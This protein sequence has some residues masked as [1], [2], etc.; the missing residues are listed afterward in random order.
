MTKNLLLYLL[1]IAF[2]FN[3]FNSFYYIMFA[4][5][6]LVLFRRKGRIYIDGSIVLLGIWSLLFAIMEIIQTGSVT[7]LRNLVYVFAFF[8]GLNMFDRPK[9]KD[10]IAVVLLLGASLSGYGLLNFIA[11]YSNLQT[12]SIARATFDFWSGEVVTATSQ[13]AYFAFFLS[14]ILTVFTTIRGK[15]L[16]LLWGLILALSFVY[17]LMLAGRTYF[18]LLAVGIVVGMFYT[19][20]MNDVVTD[21]HVVSRTKKRI[22]W[23]L[24]LV[25]LV[26]FALFSFDA[27]GVYTKLMSSNFYTRFFTNTSITSINESGRSTLMA[28]FVKLMMDYPWG[29][30]N[31]SRLMGNNVHNMWLDNYD[32]LGIIPF[33]LLVSYSCTAIFRVMQLIRDKE[34]STKL[35]VLGISV[36]M[37]LFAQYMLEPILSG[38]QWLFVAFCL[39]DGLMCAQLKRGGTKLNGY[40]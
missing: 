40:T 29:G 3:I 37:V 24:L 12:Y 23:D 7:K 36:Y 17:N 2:G 15:L 11:N 18:G 5:A 10:T 16:K 21:K 22:W 32:Q 33:V 13:A 27:F 31:I 26:V 38:I 34:I 14:T 35:R 30:S 20:T 1:I 9:E 4:I 19:T 28:E 8:A 6:F 39:F 25:V